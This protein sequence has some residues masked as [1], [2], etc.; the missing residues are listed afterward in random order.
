MA[1]GGQAHPDH[2]LT[3]G[4]V[5]GVRETAKELE[6]FADAVADLPPALARIAAAG[7]ATMRPLV[8]VRTGALRASVRGEVVNGSAV[9]SAGG[10]KVTYAGAVNARTDFIGRT[11][12][13]LENPAV[14]ELE[15]GINSE[16]KKRGLD[17]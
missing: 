6:D 4:E 12:A 2:G 7:V 14:L 15:D 1:A 11:I 13:A 8:P 17:R 10:P 9:L 3:M 5:T 16:I